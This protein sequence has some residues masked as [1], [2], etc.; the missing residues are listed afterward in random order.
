M[1]DL[2]K[3]RAESILRSVEFLKLLRP[4]GPWTLC[5]ASPTVKGMSDRTFTNPK[6][7]RAWIA[8]RCGVM[9]LYY[10][11]A[12]PKGIIHGKLAKADCAG[13]EHTHVDIDGLTTPDDKRGVV[14]VLLGFAEPVLFST[15]SARQI[16]NDFE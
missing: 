3:N 2:P 12:A 5:A 16:E 11:V 9:N 13:S 10:H 4:N 1:S 15:P 8:E 6:A 14:D 7:A